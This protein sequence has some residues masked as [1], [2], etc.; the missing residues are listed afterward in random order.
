MRQLN[1]R[2]KT[3]KL[4]FVRD[5]ALILKG[6]IQQMLPGMKKLFT[7][8]LLLT[9]FVI[10]AHA[11]DGGDKKKKKS[12]KKEA[13]SKSESV[14]TTS[15][16]NRA[17]IDEPGTVR[18]KDKKKTV[19]KDSTK[20]EAP[21]PSPSSGVERPKDEQPKEEPKEEAK[22]PEQAPQTAEASPAPPAPPGA[23]NLDASGSGT[24]LTIDEAGSQRV[25][26]PVTAPKAAD[27][28]PQNLAI[29][30]AGSQKVKT[31]VNNATNGAANPTKLTIDEPGSQ[32]V[33]VTPNNLD[34][35]S[36]SLNTSAPVKLLDLIKP[37]Q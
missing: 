20:T 30:E 23:G 37:K 4:H 33:K 8:A 29:D 32:K 10:G 18:G 3:D 5:L 25:K 12:E 24:S 17:A 11:Q 19:V 6:N 2:N 26:T 9:A 13:A 15:N 36:D 7:L 28:V 22:S 1:C 27:V 16:G 31:T 35:G 14:D 21:S 34:G